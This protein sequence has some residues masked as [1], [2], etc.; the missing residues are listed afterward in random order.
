MGFTGPEQ[1]GYTEETLPQVTDRGAFRR[2]NGY[3]STVP[4]VFVAGDAGVDSRS[5]SGPSPR[6]AR[7]PRTSIGS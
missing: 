5:S 2:D 3:E 4:G 1:D 6:A 7:P